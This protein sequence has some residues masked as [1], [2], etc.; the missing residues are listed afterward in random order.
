MQLYEKC[1][2]NGEWVSPLSRKDWTLVN[3]ATEE[4]FAIVALAGAED[5]DVAVK[6][7]RNAFASYSKT[8]KAE[9]IELL[10]GVIDRFVRHEQKLAEIVTLE[11]GTPVSQKIHA[12]AAL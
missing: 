5:V 4:A 11:L 1:Y 3:P 2:M 12:P 10:E 9:R 8:S 7:A 6:A